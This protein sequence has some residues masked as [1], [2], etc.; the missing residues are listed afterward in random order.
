MLQ[1]IIIDGSG[2]LTL[3]Q[4]TAH[5]SH[6][7]AVSNKRRAAR[8]KEL[9][10]LA[11]SLINGTP[12]PNTLPDQAVLSPKMRRALDRGRKY[13]TGRLLTA[14]PSPGK[15]TN[16]DDYQFTDFLTV[17]FNYPTLLNVPEFCTA[18]LCNQVSFDLYHALTCKRGGN[19]S[20]RHDKLLRVLQDLLG[21]AMG[22]DGKPP[23]ARSTKWRPMIQTTQGLD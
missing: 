15:G 5:T 8:R 11:D 13:K 3:N 10:A 2:T 20:Q 16:L 14:T 12:L 19:V 4:R 17:K 9:K 18:A 6:L 21:K 1:A 7:A 22:D 23:A